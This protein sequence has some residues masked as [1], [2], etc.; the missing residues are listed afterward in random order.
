MKCI[1]NHFF[2][3]G[4]TNKIFTGYFFLGLIGIVVSGYLLYSHLSYDLPDLKA[5]EKAME[6]IGKAVNG[7]CNV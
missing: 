1:W 2:G 5:R 3:Y 7:V 4:I 6:E